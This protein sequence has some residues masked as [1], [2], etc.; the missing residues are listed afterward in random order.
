VPSKSVDAWLVAAA[1]NNGHALLAGLECNLNVEAQ[2]ATLAKAQR[3]KKTTREYRA[4]QKQVTTVWS[5][6][7]QRCAQAERFSS[8]V[9]GVAL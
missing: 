5:I 7:R 4:R 1:L 9:A 6:V 8:E 2:L 3:I